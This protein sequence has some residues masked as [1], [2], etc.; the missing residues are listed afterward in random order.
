MILGIPLQEIVV[1]AIGLIAAGA[2]TGV[3][4]G[5]FGVG[6][7]AVM[8]PVLYEVFRLLDVPEAVRMPLC[9]G[10]SLAII[11]PTSVRSFQAHRARGAVDMGILRAWAVPILVGVIGGSMIARVAE[12]FVFKLAFVLVAGITATKLL[13]GR[14]SWR[15]GADLPKGPLMQAFGAVIGV[16]SSL[17]GIGGGGLSNLVMSLYNRPI[18]QS[19]ATS[20]GV[21]VLVSVPGMLGYIYAGWPKMALLPPLSLGFV[22]LIGLVLMMPSTMLTTPYGVRLAHAMPK[23]RLELAFGLFLVTVAGRFVIQM[24]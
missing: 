4:A 14:D 11:I 22:S 17:M 16:L 3:L 5:L 20:S 8:V 10:T 2:I 13:F 21:G 1:L 9:V 6:G 23:R 18:H 24:V 15:L 12:P 7:G 19:I